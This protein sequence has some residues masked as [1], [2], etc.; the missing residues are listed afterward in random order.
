MQNGAAKQNKRTNGWGDT[1]DEEEGDGAWSAEHWNRHGTIL[2]MIVSQSTV[3]VTDATR[4]RNDVA[5]RL[6]S[7][8]RGG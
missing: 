4:L 2:R 6:R 3:M 7:K 1:S 5:A 8:G